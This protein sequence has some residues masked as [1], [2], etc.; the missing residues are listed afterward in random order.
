M[1]R[2]TI[3]AEN[4]CKY[5][6]Y[7]TG[8]EAEHGVSKQKQHIHREEQLWFIP[9]LNSPTGKVSHVTTPSCTSI[10]I[11]IGGGGVHFIKADGN[12]RSIL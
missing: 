7:I 6:G 4:H 5:I 3:K 1:W 11:F 12:P 10:K 2:D 8:K 9:S